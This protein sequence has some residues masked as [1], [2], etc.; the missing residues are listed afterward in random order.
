MAL[1][2]NIRLNGDLRDAQ[3]KSVK[4]ESVLSAATE[5]LSSITMGVI[6]WYGGGLALR[7][8]GL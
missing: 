8:L 1:L 7:G 6:L 2:L 3:L 5:L 4:W